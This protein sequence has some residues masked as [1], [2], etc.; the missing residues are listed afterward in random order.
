MHFDDLIQILRRQKRGEALDEYLQK[1]EASEEEKEQEQDVD[2][3]VMEQE[4]EEAKGNDEELDDADMKLETTAL[5]EGKLEEDAVRVVTEKGGDSQEVLP[6]N[7]VK[8]LNLMQITLETFKDCRHTEEGLY[9][10]YDSLRVFL[11]CDRVRAEKVYNR[12][13]KPYFDTENASSNRGRV[14]EVEVDVPKSIKMERFPVK[15]KKNNTYQGQP[16]PCSIFTTLLLMLARIPGQA[17]DVLRAEQAEISTRAVAG[18]EDLEEAVA[19]KRKQLRPDDQDALLT[20]LD[21]SSKRRIVTDGVFEQKATYPAVALE[22]VINKSVVQFLHLIGQQ[23]ASGT[24]SP[25]SARRP[26]TMKNGWKDFNFNNTDFID[27][28]FDQNKGFTL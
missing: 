9:S 25:S 20:G 5:Q 14:F 27:L 22:G 7:P 2:D 15:T 4:E 11:G 28:T 16:T 3:V 8:R 18:D 6:N 24:G 23:V 21:R 12:H 10:I 13:I 17:G 1:Q 19:D 26:I